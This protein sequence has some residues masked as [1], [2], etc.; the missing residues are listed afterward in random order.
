MNNGSNPANGDLVPNLKA[1][2][3]AERNGEPG[4]G[5]ASKPKGALRREIKPVKEGRAR[6]LTLDDG[7]FERLEIEAK[8]RKT[9]L[10]ALAN[11]VLDRELP[12]FEVTITVVKKT[13][14]KPKPETAPA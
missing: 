8:R 10:S 4:N 14:S 6:K 7:V 2:V 1:M 3:K 5:H 12:V 11:D 13:E 9:T